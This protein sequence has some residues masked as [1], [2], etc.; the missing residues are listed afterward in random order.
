MDKRFFKQYVFIFLLFIF[1]ACKPQAVPISS[2]NLVATMTPQFTVVNTPLPTDTL[3]PTFAPSPVAN[4]PLDNTAWILQSLYSRPPLKDA[5]ITLKF[6]EGYA[7]GESGCDFYFEGGPTMKY[8][9]SA[10]GD[11]KINFVY[12]VRPCSQEVM[13]QERTYFKALSSVAG[14]NLTGDRL[15]LK[16]GIG[17]AILVFTKDTQ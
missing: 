14:Y 11:L 3:F 12:T 13:D 6:S 8:T 9:I 15:E 4:D 1:S 5:P 2:N 7:G 10:N 16:D 17:D